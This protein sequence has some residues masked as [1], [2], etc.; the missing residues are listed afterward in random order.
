MERGQSAAHAKQVFPAAVLPRAWQDYF[1]DG[2]LDDVSR[3]VIDSASLTDLFSPPPP[4]SNQPLFLTLP[5][6]GLR[7]TTSS[8][9]SGSRLTA[10]PTQRNC[11]GPRRTTLGETGMP[12]GRNATEGG[13]YS[14]GRGGS[15]GVRRSQGDP[16]E[17]G[18]VS[19]GRQ[20]C[21]PRGA[22]EERHGGRSLQRRRTL[23]PFSGPA[24]V[25]PARPSF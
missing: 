24:V 14:G 13:P 7:R 23:N 5:A 19:C 20:E 12:Y 4:I 21:L 9:S 11:R 15:R 8:R 22:R 25:F 3:G 16:E 6:Q 10:A 17:R 2:L 18:E 1:A